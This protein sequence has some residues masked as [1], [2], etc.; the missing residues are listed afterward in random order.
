[1]VKLAT[2]EVWCG[3]ALGTRTFLMGFTT[4]LP[5]GFFVSFGFGVFI[6]GWVTGLFNPHST[7]LPCVGTEYSNCK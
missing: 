6:F 3:V 2:D 1:M 7:A 5:V 4:W